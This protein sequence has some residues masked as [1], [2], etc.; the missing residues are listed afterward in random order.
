MLRVRRRGWRLA[1]RAHAKEF[2]SKTLRHSSSELSS[3]VPWAPIP[4]LLTTTSKLPKSFAAMVTARTHSRCQT[5]RTQWPGANSDVDAGDV[6]VQHRQRGILRQQSVHGRTSIPDA[7]PVT[8]AVS[9]A[10][11]IEPRAEAFD[12]HWASYL[13]PPPASRDPL[14]LK[15]SSILTHHSS[16]SALSSGFWSGSVSFHHRWVS[17]STSMNDCTSCQSPRYSMYRKG[18][19]RA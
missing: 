13:L 19:C 8:I 3:T 1:R 5:R 18:D 6:K 14:K 16:T 17:S 10:N 11:S 2:T 15:T 9:P 7:P 12:S 4:A